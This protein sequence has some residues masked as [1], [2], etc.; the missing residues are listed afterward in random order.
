MRLP[1]EKSPQD[2]PKSNFYFN[3][4]NIALF[5]RTSGLAAKHFAAQINNNSKS[6]LS[7]TIKLLF[8]QLPLINLINLSRQNT[9]YITTRK[10]L[11]CFNPIKILKDLSENLGQLLFRI[12]EIGA[13]SRD[14][15]SLPRALL[16][17]LVAIPFFILDRALNAVELTISAITFPVRQLFSHF[18]GS[19]EQAFK[20]RNNGIVIATV[21]DLREAKQLRR[22]VK[23]KQNLKYTKD[24]SYT[25]IT[26]A[27]YSDLPND[28]NDPENPGSKYIGTE[29]Q[30]LYSI[31]ANIENDMPVAIIRRTEAQAK[32]SRMLVSVVGKFKRTTLFLHQNPDVIAEASK[33][34]ITITR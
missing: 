5:S 20:Y 1:C 29:K 16:K 28:P 34:Y 22:A 13:P 7:D 17:G 33:N 10:I 31:S 12:L 23:R 8:I 14:D 19:F 3:F 11:N 2:R 32:N 24:T 21:E 6:D 25:I 15:S 9:K 26:R 27:S 18:A 4:V 30:Y